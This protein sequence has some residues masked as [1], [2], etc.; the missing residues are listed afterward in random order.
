MEI[1]ALNQKRSELIAKIYERYLP[2][3][4]LYFVNYTH[5]MMDA[6]DMA[7]NLFI[8]VLRLDVLNEETARNLLFVIAHRMIIDDVR[9]QYHVRMAKLRLE[10]GAE[11]ADT[12]SVYDELERECVRMLEERRLQT[13]AKKRAQIYRLWREEKSMKEIAEMMNISI[14]TAET[15][16]YLATREIKEYIRKAM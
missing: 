6:E 1:S 4:K 5:N 8:K 3:L 12:F 15:H 2:E 14:R 16:V 9:H 13:M 7:Q 10:D 11:V